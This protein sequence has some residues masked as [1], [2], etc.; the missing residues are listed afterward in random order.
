MKT[1]TETVKVTKALAK[2]YHFLD[3]EME[4]GKWEVKV[5]FKDG[6]VE[7]YGPYNTKKEAEEARRGMKK[8]K[9]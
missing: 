2:E 7:Y 8:S 1:Q 6:S 3:P 9:W 4:V 5:T